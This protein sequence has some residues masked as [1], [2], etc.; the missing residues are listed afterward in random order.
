MSLTDSKRCGGY[1]RLESRFLSGIPIP[2]IT[3]VQHTPLVSLRQD[4]ILSQSHDRLPVLI[5]CSKINAC[6]FRAIFRDQSW[7]CRFAVPFQDYPS[8]ACPF[9]CGILD[10]YCV[11]G[12]LWGS[13]DNRSN[14]LFSDRGFCETRPSLGSGRIREDRPG[15][16]YSRPRYRP[17]QQSN[18][19]SCF[20]TAEAGL[21]TFL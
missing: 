15:G 10:Q 17:I 4:L 20:Q 7:R 21:R 6:W 1:C 3:V 2:D 11:G 13:D 9:V 8:T 5:A 12:R 14:R 16:R 19:G 18:P